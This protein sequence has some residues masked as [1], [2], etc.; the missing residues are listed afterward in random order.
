M[1]ILFFFLDS[2]SIDRF[3]LSPSI[4]KEKWSIFFLFCFEI[5]ILIWFWLYFQFLHFD[6]VSYWEFLY[7]FPLTFGKLSGLFVFSFCFLIKKF[8]KFRNSGFFPWFFFNFSVF[9]F[10]FLNVVV[11]NFIRI[12]FSAIFPKKEKL[13]AMN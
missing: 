10:C 13:P 2:I 6:L 1:P 8:I 12:F 3:F 9:Q 7:F 4:Y 11:D 5:V